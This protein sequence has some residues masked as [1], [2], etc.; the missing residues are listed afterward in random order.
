[1]ASSNNGDVKI[2]VFHLCEISTRAKLRSSL[3]L[4]VHVFKFDL[5]WWKYCGTSAYAFGIQPFPLHVFRRLPP[6]VACVRVVCEWHR[7][8]YLTLGCK[9]LLFYENIAYGKKQRSLDERIVFYNWK[10]VKRKINSHQK[11]CSFFLCY[12]F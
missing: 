12:L 6:S 3:S 7:R 10:S 9:L 4:A 5:V 8:L 1:M 2:F 11:Y